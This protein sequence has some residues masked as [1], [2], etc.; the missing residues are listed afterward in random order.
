[1]T[2][3]DNIGLYLQQQIADAYDNLL[4][5]QK[6]EGDQLHPRRYLA[7]RL[8]EAAESFL[9]GARDGPRW[10]ILTGLRG[11]GKT[12][13]LA[14]VYTHLKQSHPGRKFNQLYI[15]L[16]DVI[17]KVA[18]VNLG[19]ILDAYQSLLGSS[20]VQNPD[21]TF[22][23]IDEVQIDP[24]WARFLKA[25][26]D[27]SRNIF[28][29]CTGSSAADLQID[30]DVAGRRARLEKLHPLNFSEYQFLTRGVPPP[31]DLKAK[32]LDVAY[33]SSTAAEAFAGLRQL[34]PEVS[35]SWSKY[36]RNSLSTYLTT[37]TLPFG[38]RYKET[39]LIYADLDKLIDRVISHDLSSLHPFGAES[40][41]VIRRLLF[42]LATTGD[43]I[44]FN[45]LTQDLRTNS[46]Q[47]W[48]MFDALQKAGL[49]IKVPA[50]G[51]H[52]TTTKR[53]AR[54]HFM[55]PALRATL[56]NLVGNPAV[57]LIRRGELLEDVA[58]LH[59]WRELV[60]GR[61]AELNHPYDKRSE[62]CDFILKF[63]ASH[64]LA[65]EF[66]LGGKGVDQVAKT[67]KKIDCRYGLVFADT[68]L[69]LAAEPG[70]ISVP[71]DYFFLM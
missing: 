4:D 62:R 51:S 61:R 63:P 12:T 40:L 60:L 8:E 21:P 36:D 30:A 25:I 10:F 45:K 26:H 41:A 24:R 20:W 3:P 65:I 2:E 35:R 59:Y 18:E 15:A 66:G 68:E 52:F 43:V 33:Y 28:F 19:Q 55:S 27:K 56:H 48:L 16:D 44:A 1:M 69:K 71:L 34:Q 70:V 38:L 31:L 42:L 37:G 29:I 64:Q 17:G 58:V 23:F 47:L 67:M 7:T 14:Q 22:L 9:D 6:R 49:I 32:L 54:Y 13:V 11:V 57:D 39:S 5:I 53:P 46:R 50:Y